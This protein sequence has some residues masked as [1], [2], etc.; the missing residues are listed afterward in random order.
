V[1]VTQNK[2]NVSTLYVPVAEKDYSKFM[3]DNAY[4]K[5]QIQNWLKTQPEL[6]PIP[7]Q[8]GFVFNG[9]SRVSKKSRFQLRQI[10]VGNEYYRLQPSWL[11]PYHQGISTHI[12]KALF[13]LRF[14]VPFWALAFVFGRNAMYWY[15]VFLAI[16]RFNLVSTTLLKASNLPEDLLADEHH[17][18]Q[19]G[20]KAYVATTVGKGCLLGIQVSAKSDQTQL[21]AAYGIFKS[22][23]Q[24]LK[25]DYRPIS[26]NTDGWKATQNVWKEL[27]EDITIIECFLHAF[28]KIRQR[29]TAKL[30]N[31]FKEV[32]NKVW[33]IYQALN[34]RSFAQRF[35]RFKEWAKANIDSS[36][37]KENSLKMCDKA[38]LFAQF[39]D[40]PQ[41]FRTSTALDRIMRYMA[42]H[43]YNSQNFH[44]SISATSKNYRAFALLYNFS[45]LSPQ[46]IKDAP[47]LYSLAAKASGVVFSEDW[48]QNLLICASVGKINHH[49]NPL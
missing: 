30:E 6:F 33:S 23:A 15:R 11:L 47:V 49:C 12:S 34:K 28:L 7:M 3:K 37:M 41:A 36:P 2:Q 20:N 48:L 32:S 19:K 27:F 18:R 31:T 14:G 46:T 35:R 4:A 17:I 1:A 16:G 10:K 39:Y 22:E 45:P 40:R 5:Q 29:A 8:S 21:R 43:A 26:V 9:K 25:P 24:S 44:S 38:K 42:R 13:L